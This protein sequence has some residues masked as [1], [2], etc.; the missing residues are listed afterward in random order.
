MI[1]RKVKQDYSWT[2][3]ELGKKYE[4]IQLQY[5]AQLFNQLV[6]ENKID[7]NGVYAFVRAPELGAVP[8]HASEKNFLMNNNGTNFTNL[9]CNF[10]L[11][12]FKEEVERDFSIVISDEE[13]AKMLR[14]LVDKQ[15]ATLNNELSETPDKEVEA[16][17]KS[18][19]NVL[20]SISDN[21]AKSLFP[22]NR[23]LK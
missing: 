5:N 2:D 8:L 16:L 18:E 13:E 4:V 1:L 17:A 10:D 22:K 6:E 9:S 21:I 20:I 19:L 11:E 15:I 23:W 7:S 14:Q 3:I 12:R